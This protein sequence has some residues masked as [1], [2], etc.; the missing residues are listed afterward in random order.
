LQNEKKKIFVLV[1]DEIAW[2]ADTET[3]WNRALA[4]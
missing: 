1:D 3:Q 2:S 4:S